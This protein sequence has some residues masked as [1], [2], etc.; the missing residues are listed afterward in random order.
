MRDYRIE[1]YLVRP[2]ENG[3]IKARVR[4]N[5]ECPLPNYLSHV[6]AYRRWNR[7]IVVE[8][9]EDSELAASWNTSAVWNKGTRYTVGVKLTP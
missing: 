8:S 6:V 7:S 9:S 5:I 2:E 3:K 1:R 4:S